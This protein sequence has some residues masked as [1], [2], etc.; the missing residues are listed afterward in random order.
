MTKIGGD[1]PCRQKTK[2]TLKTKIEQQKVMNVP[3][4]DD[5]TES[6]S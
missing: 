3:E 2:N 4:E 5:G 1:K 6:T